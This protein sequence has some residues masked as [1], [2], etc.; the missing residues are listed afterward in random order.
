[1]DS[2]SRKEWRAHTHTY[3]HPTPP[4]PNRK[5]K[6]G[7][8]ERE[9]EREREDVWREKER[10]II[11]W[12]YLCPAQQ[13]KPRKEQQRYTVRYTAQKIQSNRIYK[14]IYIYMELYR[15]D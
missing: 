13:P 2:S 4:H 7:R 3:T 15:I 8:R 10:D 1:M 14:Y 6:K 5:E 9:R 12:G 11:K